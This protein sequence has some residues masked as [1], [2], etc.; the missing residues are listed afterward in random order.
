MTEHSA[1][2]GPAQH[3]AGEQ[4]EARQSGDGELVVLRESELE[5]SLETA[6]RKLREGNAR[7]RILIVSPEEEDAETDRALLEPESP[8]TE[9]TGDPSAQ[10][11]QLH[12]EAA[13]IRR[14]G[15]AW[16]QGA[17]VTTLWVR[18]LQRQARELDL[19]LQ[20][21]DSEESRSGWA[22]LQEQIAW[23]AE[24]VEETRVLA[25]KAAQ[26]MQS[27]ELSSLVQEALAGLAPTGGSLR[28]E[29]PEHKTPI[30]GNAWALFEAFR[31]CAEILSERIRAQGTLRITA[32][33]GS[34][35][36]MTEFRAIPDAGYSDQRVAKAR[37][38]RL[39]RLIEEEHG[40]KV[41]PGSRSDEAAILLAIPLRLHRPAVQ[42]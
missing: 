21:G 41:L 25:A 33:E 31:T 19:A 2:E 20:K 29:V 13:A 6:V 4:E 5:E 16:S 22:R 3:Q 10:S 38:S 14:S 23:L 18:E 40:G 12:R 17:E 34:C 28:C 7:A 42:I 39:R 30:H 9:R 15:E 1:I 24:T 36:V 26:G 32:R 11:R 37:L 8:R 35:F 27:L